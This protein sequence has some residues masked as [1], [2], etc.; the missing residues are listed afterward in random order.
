MGLLIEAGGRRYLHWCVLRH[1][2]P[3]KHVENTVG[4]AHH[5]MGGHGLQLLHFTA[6]VNPSNPGMAGGPPEPE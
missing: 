4:G 1:A 5:Y 6:D 2:S 3:V